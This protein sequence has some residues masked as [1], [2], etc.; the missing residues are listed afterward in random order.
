MRVGVILPARDE[1]P[2]LGATLAELAATA[3]ASD[4]LRLLKVIVVDN[5]SRDGTA[6]AARRA[7]VRVVCEPRRGYGRACLAGIA[8]LP[9]DTE[10]V[11]FCDADGSS[12]PA[13]LPAL[14]APIARGQADL[15]IGTRRPGR[16]EPGAMTPPQRFGTRLAVSLLGWLH[17]IRATDLGPFRAIRAD[18]LRRLPMRDTGFGWTIE[19][20]I[21]AARAGLRVVE[22]PVSWRRRRAGKSKISGTV[23]GTLG[24]GAK[25]LWTVL[26]YR[27]EKGYRKQDGGRD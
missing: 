24:A 4:T 22:V 19:M 7:G 3:A 5:G 27:F 10:V 14:L 12:D 20:Q 25:I 13:E 17:G 18:A 1:E 15:V 16:V 9:A 8:A 11:V 23:G 26:R 21:R 2:A 6:G